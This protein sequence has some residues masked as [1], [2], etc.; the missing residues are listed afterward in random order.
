MIPLKTGYPTSPNA[1]TI[2]T[3]DIKHAS[4]HRPGRSASNPPTVL[5]SD[6]HDPLALNADTLAQR[7]SR[8]ISSPPA[9]P[10]R[11]GASHVSSLQ[12][13]SRSASTLQ[14]GHSMPMQET[15]AQLKAV[16]MPRVSQEYSDL[17][18][19]HEQYSKEGPSNAHVGPTREV[20]GLRLHV[21]PPF[22]MLIVNLKNMYV[23]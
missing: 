5:A 12:W 9:V 3:P 21:Y 16:T 14:P 13:S 23:G 10:L 15:P 1:S 18:E 19:E 6:A 8:S 2:K 22:D 20:D 7:E 11:A 4:L 17:D